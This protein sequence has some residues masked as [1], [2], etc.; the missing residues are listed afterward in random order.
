[1]YALYR[2]FKGMKD[3]YS[4]RHFIANKI[5]LWFHSSLWTLSKMIWSTKFSILSFIWNSY[6]TWWEIIYLIS[7]KIIQIANPTYPYI[8]STVTLAIRYINLNRGQDIH[9]IT[10]YHMFLINIDSQGLICSW[11]WIYK[12]AYTR[13]MRANKRHVWER[14]M[15]K[16]QH[17]FMVTIGHLYIARYSRK[18][19]KCAYL[20]FTWIFLRF[21]RHIGRLIG[22]SL[23]FHF[24]II[25]LLCINMIV[26]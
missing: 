8:H 13:K 19:Q 1:M 7:Y 23:F 2:M 17:W 24:T 4:R 12:M 25:L 11:C 20:T 9:L 10:S 14:R 22:L 16:G 18:L 3:V 6:P 15:R 5:S 21:S 26:I